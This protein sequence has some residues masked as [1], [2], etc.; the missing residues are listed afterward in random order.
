MQGT[1]GS[2]AM[3]NSFLQYRNAGAA[4]RQVLIDAAAA[5]WGVDAAQVTISERDR[6]GAMWRDI[7]DLDPMVGTGGGA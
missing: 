7:G 6:R 5:D 2:T 1:G 3:A 4:A